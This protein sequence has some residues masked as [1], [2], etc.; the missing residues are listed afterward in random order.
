MVNFEPTQSQYEVASAIVAKTV[1]AFWLGPM[2]LL[3]LLVGMHSANVYST[4][5]SG[6][7]SPTE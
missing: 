7:P 5:S 6:M 1:Y 2:A 4:G 3:A